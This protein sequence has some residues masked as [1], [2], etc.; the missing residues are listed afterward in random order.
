MDTQAMDLLERYLQAIGQY[1]PEETR[2][3]T[4]AELRANLLDQMEAREEESGRP[5]TAPDAAA[6]L[7]EH[8]KPELVAPR[9]LPQRSL[10]GP[11][12]FPFYV[13]TLKR[14]LPLVVFIY[15]IAQAATLLAKHGLH[16]APVALIQSVIGLVSTL[17][18]YCAWVTI[19]FVVVEEVLRR[20]GVPKKWLEW[21]PAKL[22]PLKPENLEAK[23]KSTAS[24]I[25]ELCI[26]VLWLAYVLLL[27][28]HPALLVGP[29]AL[30]FDSLGV[31]FAP[32]WHLFFELFIAALLI[33]LAMKIVAVLP[34]N[35]T[36]INPA[37]LATDALGLVAVGVMVR[38][39]EYFVPASGAA[40]LQKIAHVNHA[41]GITFTIA[42]VCA[43]A[44]FLIEAWKYLRRSAPAKALAF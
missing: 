7:K 14:V 36:W 2:A 39:G 4:M 41:I 38:T 3:D 18:V 29:G 33:Q 44:G 20:R 9:Y 43:L 35:R 5:L 11:T 30:Y 12:V 23:P 16:G 8:G 42:F 19:A 10:I 26:Q 17:V 13:Y 25:V 31:R 40:N 27:P 22:P 37:K 28:T 24:R 1:L 21:D 6:M 34:G 15:A 32:P